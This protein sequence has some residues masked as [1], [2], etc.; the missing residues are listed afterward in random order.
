MPGAVQRELRQTEP[1]QVR[2][3]REGEQKMLL[4]KRGTLGQESRQSK[5]GQITQMAGY[6]E[7]Q[8]NPSE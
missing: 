1:D 4:T 2:R 6:R 7:G 8:P 5:R 3:D